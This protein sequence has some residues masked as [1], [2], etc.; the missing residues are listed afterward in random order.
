MARYS[1]VDP[2]L[3]HIKWFCAVSIKLDL[4]LD[5]IRPCWD[6]YI[7]GARARRYYY[8]GSCR[9]VGIVDDF[10]RCLSCGRALWGENNLVVVRQTILLSVYGHDHM[11]FEIVGGR[12]HG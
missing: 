3:D 4:L 1:R 9:I 10:Q 7:T 6:V 11:I 2:F 12:N 8:L 5:S